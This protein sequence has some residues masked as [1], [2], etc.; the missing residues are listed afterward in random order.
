FIARAEKMGFAAKR[1]ALFSGEIVNLSEGR[2]AT[3]V[4]ERGSGAAADVAMATA[5]RQR[6]RA[7]VDAIEAGAFGDVTGILHIGIGGSVLGPAL[8]VDALGRRSSALTVRFLSNIDGAAFDDAV[9]PLDPAT[10]IIVVASK[11]FT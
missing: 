5:Q 10:T 2:A 8:L 4:A 1:D 9:K 6:M 7:L 11:T 3:H